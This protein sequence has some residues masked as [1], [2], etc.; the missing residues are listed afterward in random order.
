MRTGALVVVA[1]ELTF[2]VRGLV[3]EH[4]S[5]A[6]HPFPEEAGELRRVELDSPACHTAC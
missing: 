2:A 4:P 3:A 6:S 5:M 1:G